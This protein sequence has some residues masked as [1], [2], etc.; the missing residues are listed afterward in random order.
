MKRIHTSVLSIILCVNLFAQQSPTVQLLHR[1]PIA[2][3]G[4]WD[5]LAV[6]PVSD[7]LYVSHGTQVN[8]IHK[9]SGDS[10]GV[11]L[12]TTGVHG[13]AF[14]PIHKKGFTS[15]G[16]LN[17]V[18]A[19][20][21][22]THQ[23]LAQIPT[24]INPDAILFE[25][26]SK[27]I[28]T[29]NGKSFTLSIIDPEN[30]QLLDSIAV[31]GKPETAVTD[32]SGNLW[33]NI[34]DKN[35]IVQI[36]TKTFRIINRFSLPAS[37]PTGLAYDSKYKRLFAGC[38]KKLVVLDAFTGITIAQVPIGAGCDGVAFDQDLQI[39]YTSNGVAGTLSVIKQQDANKYVHL[40]DLTTQTSARTITIDPV[41]H[42]VY[43]PA[44]SFE[45][46]T[47][48]TSGRG[49]MIP[50]SFQVLVVGPT[51]PKLNQ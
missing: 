8:I 15:N 21:I 50:G 19:F 3:N 31:G 29:C 26:Y 9:T 38:D 25:P 6:S 34:E 42:W 37:S 11:L 2:S 32:A 30:N 23:V 43:L 10:V 17:T 12:N 16:R 36:S 22:R 13:I 18:T 35:E 5:Y 14:D 28:I 48:G 27:K 49:K 51:T 45:P 39:I 40:Q 24:G 44:A 1:F 46:P 20:D 4:G 47:P 41:T 7:W 33:V